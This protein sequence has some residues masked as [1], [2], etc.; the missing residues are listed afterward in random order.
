ARLVRVEAVVSTSEDRRAFLYD[1][2]LAADSPGWRRVAWMDTDGRLRREPVDADSADRSLAVRHRAIVAE[3]GGG[4]VAC[5]PPPHQ[6]FF[7]RH[8]T[9]NLRYACAGRGH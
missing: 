3:A 1:A 6:F 4:S 2:G 5:F 7:P 9:D 8:L